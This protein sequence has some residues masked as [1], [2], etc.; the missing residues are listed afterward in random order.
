MPTVPE[1]HV[2]LLSGP[3]LAT[4]TTIAPDGVPENTIVWSMWDGEHVLVC[5]AAGRRKDKNIRKNPH[6]ALCVLD[7]Q[8]GSRWI[9]VR[10]Y[11]AEIVP[12]EDYAGIDAA[13]KLY[14]GAG[15]FYGEVAP[16]EL[17]G[18]QERIVFKISPDRVTVSP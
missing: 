3:Y 5:T 9:D 2:D 11:V 14:T 16:A 8:D 13:A 18:T 4:F 17:E 1:S 6:V 15:R 7:P 10:G 12:D